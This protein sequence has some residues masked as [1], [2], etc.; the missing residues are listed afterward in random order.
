MALRLCLY[1]ALD[2]LF[3]RTIDGHFWRQEKMD[4]LKFATFLKLC[5]KVV[6]NGGRGKDG[7]CLICLP[8][9]R[10]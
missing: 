9:N 8:K 2:T 4:L 10:G 6:K 1:C 7:K 5:R 3:L